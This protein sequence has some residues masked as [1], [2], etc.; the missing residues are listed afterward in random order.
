MNIESERERLSQEKTLECLRRELKPTDMVTVSLIRGEA[1]GIYCTLIPLVQIDQVRSKLHWEFQPGE[2]IPDSTIVDTGGEERAKYLRF[3]VDN[4]TEPLVID[5]RFWGMRDDY[6]EI[7]EEFRHFHNLYHDKQTDRYI[8]FDDEGNEEIVAIVKPERIRIR[9]KEIRQFLAIKEMFLWIQFD[10]TEFSDHS[11]EELVSEECRGV[12]QEGLTTWDLYYGSAGSQ[13]FSRF[14]GKRLVKPLPKSKSG[15]KDFVGKSER[16]YVEF[17]IDVDENGDEIAHTSDPSVL[18]N[19]FGANLG[20]PL[21]LTPV[22][23]RKQVLEKYYR[24]PSKYSI[25]DS[26]LRCGGLWGLSIDNHHTDKVCAWLGDLGRHLPYREQLH[27]RTYNTPPAGG[28]S[29]TYYRRQVLG[30]WAAT[31]QPDLLFRERYQEL[32]EEGISHLG[33]HILK[34]LTSGDEHHFQALRVPT[35]DEQRDFDELVLS[36]TKI[37]IDSL[38]VKRLNSLLTEEQKEGLEEGS[39]ARLEAVL[40]SRNIEGAADHIAFLRKLQSLRSSSSAHRKGSKYRKVAKQFNIESQNLRDVFVGILWQAL[41]FLNFLILLARSGRADDIEKNRS[42]E[43]YAILDEMVGFVE[44]G[45]TDGSVN[46]DD[47]IYELRTKP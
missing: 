34:P 47:L 40:A 13:A 38:H 41:D 4:G 36:L 11:L 28:V 43:M 5:R 27:W 6:Q 24:Q 22:Y 46:H 20:A 21:F 12:Q 9:L 29:K 18:A 19:L 17:I 8:R 10:F 44:S 45:A 23:F 35:T 15:F 30:Q 16:E 3:G 2:G 31:D 39:I 33:W 1:S 37:L 7:S 32:K 14:Q 26:A 25:E 42:E